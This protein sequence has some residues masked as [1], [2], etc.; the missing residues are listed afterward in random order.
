MNRPERAD[1]HDCQATKHIQQM[2]KEEIYALFD[3]PILK[4]HC[5]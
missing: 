3:S 5:Y 4:L 2:E 1:F